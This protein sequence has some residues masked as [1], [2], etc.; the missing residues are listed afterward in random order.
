MKFTQIDGNLLFRYRGVTVY[1]WR[2]PTN[3]LFIYLVWPYGTNL[4]KSRQPVSDNVLRNHLIVANR[5]YKHKIDTE[6]IPWKN[7]LHEMKGAV[8]DQL[9]Q[10]VSRK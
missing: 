6:L 2:D 8:L 3:Y 9:K 7:D 5:V 1:W 4:R 10:L